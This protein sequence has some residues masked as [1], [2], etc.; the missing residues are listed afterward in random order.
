MKIGIDLDNTIIRYDGL[1]HRL[2]LAEGF[3]QASMPVNKQ[4]IRD[5][6][7]SAHGEA[8]WQ[9]LQLALYGTAIEN[10]CLFDGVWDFLLCLRRRGIPFHIVSHKTRFPNSG[11]QKVD[12]RL[13][14]LEFLDSHG[15]FRAD[16]LGMPS[17]NV[18][19]CSRRAEKVAAIARLGHTAFIDDLEE[20]FL[21]PGFPAGT[22]KI[23]FS[24]AS[25]SR[26]EGVLI[27]PDF[28]SITRALLGA[29][30]D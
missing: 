24:S 5:H 12:L 8:A 22:R 28:T 25:S 10:A 3:I 2:A 18:L 23:L 17:E 1:L 26:A 4:A 19:F 29:T 16:G 11:S 15:F 30:C 27:L 14:A 13:K 9:G 21:E 6:V 20:V 7:R